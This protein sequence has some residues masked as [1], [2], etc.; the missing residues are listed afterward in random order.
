MKGILPVPR[1][2]FQ[3]KKT[4]HSGPELA[5]ATPEPAARRQLPAHLTAEARG[6]IEAKDQL[7]AQRRAHLREGTLEL[8]RRYVVEKKIR[9][10]RLAKRKAAQVVRKNAPER[11]DERLTAATVR[12]GTMS[13]ALQADPHAA[14]RLAVR[15]AKYAALVAAQRERRADALH[16]LYTR[17]SDFIV[18]EPSL[19]AAVEAAFSTPFYA[20]NPNHSVWDAEGMPETLPWLVAQQA[21][22][23]R[24][25]EAALGRSNMQGLEPDGRLLTRGRER[26]ERMA[27]LLTRQVGAE[28]E[29]GRNC[30]FS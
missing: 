30:C 25:Y 15:R 7:A 9:D 2:P 11:E 3:R 23:R 13:A 14:E 18:D 17:A 21:T 19:H 28:A 24:A 20:R 16:A 27:D 10:T 5:A 4:R 6:R 26:A 1:H 29:A 12:A 8:H 22:S